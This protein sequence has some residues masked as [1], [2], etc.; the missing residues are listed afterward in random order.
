M[1]TRLIEYFLIGALNKTVGR[2]QK[3]E[4]DE[5]LPALPSDHSVIGRLINDEGKVTKQE[6]ALSPE[7]R[8]RHLYLL[9]ATGTGK[10][11]LLLRLIESDIANSRAFCVIDLR[12]D[13]VDRI[14]L[15]LAANAPPEES[16]KGRFFS[17]LSTKSDVFVSQSSVSRSNRGLGTPIPFCLNRSS[18]NINFTFPV[19]FERESS[20]E[21]IFSRKN[22]PL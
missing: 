8:M 1:L 14:L 21:H 12:G 17:G 11:N 10:T 20:S 9:G 18:R 15:R 6:I 19:R 4:S 13:L 3:T 16:Y 22:L 2:S 7:A 5:P